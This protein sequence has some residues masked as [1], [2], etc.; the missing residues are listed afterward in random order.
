MITANINSGVILDIFL[1]IML[2]AGQLLPA[3]ACFFK[4]ND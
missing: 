1:I 4:N 3:T 2:K